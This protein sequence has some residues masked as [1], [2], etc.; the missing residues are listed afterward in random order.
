M[1]SSCVIRYCR[2]VMLPSC[3]I[4]MHKS[5][6]TLVKLWHK[7]DLVRFG[8]RPITFGF[9][10]GMQ[11][12]PLLW[13]CW[14]CMSGCPVALIISYWH[15]CVYI[16]VTLKPTESHPDSKGYLLYLDDK[17]K[18]VTK[19][20]VFD[21]PAMK[22]SCSAA[23]LQGSCNQIRVERMCYIRVFLGLIIII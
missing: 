2:F 12:R 16:G 18:D 11:P 22:L 14:I 21:T 8:K 10:Q 13:L 1:F 3:L 9:L 15:G 17:L 19:K 23:T 20:M 7:N 4:Q 5:Q 6:V